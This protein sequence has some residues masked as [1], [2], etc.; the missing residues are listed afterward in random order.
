MNALLLGLLLL[1]S[2]HDCNAVAVRASVTHHPLEANP[3]EWTETSGTLD[4]KTYYVA[5]DGAKLDP[6]RCPDQWFIGV[7]LEPLDGAPELDVVA[8]CHD[9]PWCFRSLWTQRGSGIPTTASR[10]R[11]RLAGGQQWRRPQTF[12]SARVVSVPW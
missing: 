10:Y 11:I 6:R 7:V 4:V 12:E 1:G 9:F 5:A 8:D 3:L 2:P